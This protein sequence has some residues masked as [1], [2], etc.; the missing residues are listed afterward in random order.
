MEKEELLTIVTDFYLSKRDFNGFPIH[1]LVYL[2]IPE[3]TSSPEAPLIK[4][5]T[6]E[7]VI[8]KID[9]CKGK[10]QELIV[11]LV[12][13]ELLTVLF[14]DLHPNPHIKAFRDEPKDNV[15]KKI[16]TDLLAHACL[17][18]ASKH[19]VEAV[20][21]TEYAD[22][23]FTLELALGAGQLEFNT[24]DLTVLERYRNDPRYFYE[25]DD[26]A[27][28]ICI[29]SEFY[30]SEEMDDHDKILL[31]S[32]GF[33]Y[34]D[35]SDRAVAAFNI[36]LNR[37]SPEH[38]QWWNLKKTK[39]PY[40]LHPDYYRTSILG[41]WRKGT[42]IFTAFLFEQKAIN[43]IC[44]QI[45]RPKFFRD[46]YTDDKRPREFSFMLRPTAKEFQDFAL[47]LD[48]MMSDNINKAFFM[49]DVPKEEDRPRKDGKIVVVQ[50][51]TIR[52]LEMWLNKLFKANKPNPVSD[53][54]GKFKAIRKERQPVA[55]QID[56]NTFN[57]EYYHRQRKLIISA[58]EAVNALRN[59]LSSHP[60]AV[61]YTPLTVIEK[62]TPADGVG[63]R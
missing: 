60:K 28:R 40:K 47:L 41:S 43:E 12:D 58:Y 16:D 54:I 9:K 38:Q 34:N 19:L 7:E 5:I 62:P 26:I 13:A 23:P 10:V 53:V 2:L 45:N 36:Y 55:H 56:D 46:L 20:D 22:K 39:E 14:G 11:P 3:T 44:D 17:Y 42:S 37:L 33:A 50:I 52:M 29:N 8:E 32:F 27:G 15:L 21:I 1:K 49:N 24:F 48:K 63:P 18:P 25:A 59:I 57:Q 6:S 30:K 51:G 31:E 61:G 35:N 4:F